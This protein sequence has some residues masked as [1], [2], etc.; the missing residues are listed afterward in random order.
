VTSA[1]IAAI[2]DGDA[3]LR[4]LA[5][6]DLPTTMAWRNHP[7][8]RRWFHSTAEVSTEQHAE[9]FR[10][11]LERDD[12]YVF[13]LEI[14]GAPVAQVS[15]YDVRGGT[16]EFGRLLVDP[17]ARGRGISH[18]AVALCLRVADG[19][20]DLSETHLEVKPDNTRA[21]AAYE[22]AGFRVDDARAGTAGS[23]VMVREVR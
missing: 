14:G 12:D 6:A 10:R 1:T 7:E 17:A 20:L 18:T 5:E 23:L 11:Y 13:V 22:T 21:I 16:A 19:V 4:M 9:W 3:T 15:L 2:V 8:S